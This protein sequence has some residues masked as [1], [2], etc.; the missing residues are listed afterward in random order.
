MSIVTF[1]KAFY[2]NYFSHRGAQMTSC[3]AFMCLNHL[4]LF[5]VGISLLAPS[6]FNETPQ[7]L[8]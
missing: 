5:S 1:P 3:S 2:R 7:R 8:P 6:R 4:P